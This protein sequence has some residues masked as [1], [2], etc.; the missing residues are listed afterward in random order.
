V[1]FPYYSEG[2]FPRYSVS[3]KYYY[4]LFEIIIK[5][6]SRQSRTAKKLVASES[7]QTYYFSDVKGL[8]MLLVIHYFVRAI[9][10]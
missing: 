7:R 1:L 5:E 2:Y 10:N 3:I 9:A 8:I 4:L 6:D